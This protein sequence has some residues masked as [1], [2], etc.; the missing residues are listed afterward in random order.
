M[1]TKNG[2]KELYSI[3]LIWLKIR[4]RSPISNWLSKA[5]FILGAMVV[6]TPLIEQLVFT[7]I[8]KKIFGIDIGISVPDVKAYIAGS[9]LIT[10][11]MAHNLLFVKL[12]Q[13][14]AENQRNIKTSI[15][16]E[17]WVLID[18]M[19]D[20]TVRLTNLYCTEYKEAD[21]SYATTCEDA[22]IKA[23]EHARKNRPFYF[24]EDFY[25]MVTN[26]STTCL[27]QAASFRECI[28]MKKKDNHDYSF[29]LAQESINSEYRELIL[30]YDKICDEIRSYISAI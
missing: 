12:N 15:Y 11:A 18:D 4:V 13:Q 30:N 20:S 28:T 24:S 3:F 14:H 17:I 5:A 23:L 26:L 1:T 2:R 22:I 25:K 8:L 27:S 7:A 10:A 9:F 29:Y 16:K 21:D 6:S 19:I